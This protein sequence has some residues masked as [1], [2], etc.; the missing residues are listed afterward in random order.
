MLTLIEG[1]Q[2]IMTQMS[3]RWQQDMREQA[4][5]EQMEMVAKM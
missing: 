2:V 5:K 3:Y 4:M 1:A